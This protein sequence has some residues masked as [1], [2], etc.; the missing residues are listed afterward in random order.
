MI[1]KTRSDEALKITSGDKADSVLGFLK[2]A[3]FI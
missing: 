1:A 2:S 3:V